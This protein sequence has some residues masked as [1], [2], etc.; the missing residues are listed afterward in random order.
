MKK[1]GTLI[2]SVSVVALVLLLAAGGFLSASKALSAS[3]SENTSGT[4]ADSAA[5]F[6]RKNAAAAQQA[7]TTEQQVVKQTYI[8]EA[9]Q[10]LWE[11]AQENGV[12]VQTL[13]NANRLSSSLIIEGQ[14]LI[15]Q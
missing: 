10:T 4:T 8:V 1:Q 14:E 3:L 7:P 9:G 2:Y 5:A 11:I 6:E 12:T 13:M 15:I